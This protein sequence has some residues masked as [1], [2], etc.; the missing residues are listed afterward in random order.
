MRRTGVVLAAATA[1]GFLAACRE[2]RSTEPAPTANPALTGAWGTVS[3]SGSF[4]EFSLRAAGGAI[5]GAGREFRSGSFYDSLIVS[6]EYSDTSAFRLTIAY[7]NGDI[8][9]YV[10]VAL[11]PTLMAGTWSRGPY[12]YG[13]FDREFHVRPRAPCA[14]SAGLD[15][16]PDPRAPGYIVM[17]YRS[18]DSPT[19]T[20]RLAALYHFTPH[21]VWT[22]AIEGF[23][24]DLLPTTVSLV[25]CDT[26][27]EL[28]EY[29]AVVAFD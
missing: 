7:T 3:S 21:F 15:G 16:A 13:P 29:N 1:A 4:V 26:L 25:R 9:H 17:Y 27:V 23:A 24:A 19:E 20:A 22:H 10:G 11:T 2:S 18:V 5:T 28:I 14:D 12:D 8:A 6:G